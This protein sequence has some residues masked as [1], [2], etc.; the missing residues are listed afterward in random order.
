[1][2]LHTASCRCGA[3]RFEARAEPFYASYCHCED[4]RRA[5]G[6]PVAAFVGF[7]IRDARFIGEAPGTYGAAPVTRSFCRT[8]GAP[9]SY[10]DARLPDQIFMMLGAMDAPEKYPPTVHGYVSEALPFFHIA[11]G[12][13][14]METS[15]VPRP[16]EDGQ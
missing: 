13:P 3:I 12:L 6:S 14:Q 10:V 9:L 8:C 7:Y 16:K 1:M 15:T 4:C 11:D 2:S 5:S